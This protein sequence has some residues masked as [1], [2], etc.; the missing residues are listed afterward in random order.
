MIERYFTPEMKEIFSEENKYRK[1]ITVEIAALEVLEGEGIIEPG[2]T[3]KIKEYLEE[4]NIREFTQR[5]KEIEREVEHDVIA[6]LIALEEIVGNAG[7]YIHFG[8]TSSDVVDTA[9]ALILK[10]GVEVLL[11]ELELLIKAVE[12]K[13]LEYKAQLIMGR[14]HGVYA[15]PTSLGLKFL[16]FYS[17]L[18]RCRERLTRALSTISYGKISGAVGNYAYLSPEVEEKILER[19]GLTPE[20]ISTQIIPRDRHA[21]LITQIAI[22]GAS[23]ERFA[24]EIR[25]LQRTEVKE[26]EEPFTKGQRGSSA[27][28]HKRNPI[29]SERICGLARLLRGYS[30]TALENIALWHERDISHSSAER[31]IFVDSISVLHYMLRLMRYIIEN[32]TVNT[33]IIVKNMEKYGKFYYSQALLLELVKKGVPRKDAYA[34]VKECAHTAMD[35]NLDFQKVVSEHPGIRQYLTN[36]EIEKVFTKDFLVNLNKIYKRFGLS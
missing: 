25:L 24:T 22:T 2:V 27:M 15:E 5:A 8:L 31:F 10:E 11:K 1:W 32:L 17:E 7:R 23:L 34:W 9:N 28:P 36:E 12:S 35:E 33:E 30:V 4:L 3:Q 14:T 6:F 21:F 19:L 20:P 26:L 16:Y 18:N 29:R 13:A